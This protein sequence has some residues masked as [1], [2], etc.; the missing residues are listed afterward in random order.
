VNAIV[1]SPRSK[2]VLTFGTVRNGVACTTPSL[3]MRIPPARST[4]NS[5]VSSGGE[6][7]YI[8]EEAKPPCTGTSASPRATSAS[9]SSASA[10]RTAMRT[11]ARPY[12]QSD[13]R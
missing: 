10:V 11:T 5:R 12:R 1:D 6:V 4:T 8:G 3:T 13:V 2:F 7:T 9:A